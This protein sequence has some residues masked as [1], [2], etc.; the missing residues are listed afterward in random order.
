MH[1]IFVYGTLKRGYP[2]AHVGMPRATFI[3]EYR[4]MERY[5][6]VIGGRWF[7][8]Y[9]INEPGEGFRVTGEAY[10]VDD[11]VLAELDELESV[12]LPDGYRRFEIAIEPMKAAV[13]ELGKAWTYLRERRHIDGI[14]DGP[15]ETYPLDAGYVPAKERGR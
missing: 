8:P 14:H 2:N 9:L 12:H 10:L 13:Q 7:S 3:G 5:P 15:M 11:A 1:Q 6:L 4:T